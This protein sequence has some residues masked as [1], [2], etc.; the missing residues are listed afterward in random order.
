[1][2]HLQFEQWLFERQRLEASEA[3]ELEAHLEACEACRNLAAGWQ[4]VEAELR[5]GRQLEVPMGFVGRFQRR[6]NMERNRRRARRIVSVLVP[7]SLALIAGV[8][9]AV[10][11]LIS[12]LPTIL[13]WSLKTIEQLR[14]V[15]ELLDVVGDFLRILLESLAGNIPAFL[16]LAVPALFSAL[17]FAWL[18]SLYRLSYRRVERE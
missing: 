4:G 6:L 3:A 1:M 12:R 16:W 7:M 9:L 11:E 18:L 17:S 5:R 8:G 15:A 2:G 10:A 14:W 13:A